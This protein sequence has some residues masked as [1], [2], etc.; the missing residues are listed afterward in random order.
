MGTLS[1]PAAADFNIRIMEPS[2][3]PEIEAFIMNFASG[4][5]SKSAAVMGKKKARAKFKVPM[6][7]GAAAGTAPKMGKLWQACGQLETLVASTSAAYTPLATKDYGDSINASI[8]MYL[9][10]ASGNSVILTMKGAMGNCVVTMDDLGQPLL[11]DFDFLGCFVSIAD[12]ATIALTSPDTDVP[13]GTIGSA[14][15]SASIVQRIAKFKLDFGNTVEMDYDPADTTSGYLAAY[16]ASREPKIMIDPRAE[17]LA[18]DAQYTRW[19]AG[20]EA[21]FS[22][23]TPVNSASLKYV[24]TAPKFQILNLKVADRNSAQIWDIEGEL[25]ESTGNDSHSILISA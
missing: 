7:T 12:G 13:P 16:I 1:A 18:T 17:L 25:H 6:R 5:H 10:P 2:F 4:R 19:A 3:E 9:T 14:I 8:T 21:A 24:I 20:T 15:T 22:F 23:T 11:A